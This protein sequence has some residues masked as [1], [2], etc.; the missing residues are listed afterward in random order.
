MGNYIIENAELLLEKMNKFDVVE[1]SQSDLS[2]WDALVDDSSHGTIFHKT[3]WLNACAR[4]LKK[5][6]KIFGCFQDGHLVGGTS[7]FLENK[8]FGFVPV[9]SSTCTMT[10]FGGFVLSAPLSAGVHKQE[11]FSRKIIESLIREIKKEHFFSV[12][13][14]NSPDFLDIRPFIVNGWKSRV[15]YAYSVNLE[16]NL[17]SHADLQV[18][19]NIRKAEKNGI[20]IESFSDISRYYTLFSEMN[21]RKDL[22]I[23]APKDLFTEIYSF[24]SNF[25]CGEM[26]A[27]KTPE[28]EMAC[29]EIVVW[30][31]KKAYRWAAASD[32]RFLDSGAPSLLLFNILKRM[33]ERGVPKIN[34]MGANTT[35]LSRFLSRFNPTLVPYYQIQS[36]FFDDFLSFNET[37]LE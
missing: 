28:N 15:L 13:I 20:T 30:D 17:E 27:A 21:A 4:S 31:N 26:V 11:T 5:K 24:I 25:N 29:A 19:K 12:R 7:L 2:Q 33:Q 8:K 18:K 16:D 35:Q 14:Q 6:V 9:A 36:G 3:G 22:K 37:D 1:L 10:P 34:L 32:A 23:P